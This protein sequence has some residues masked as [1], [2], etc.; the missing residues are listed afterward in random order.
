M[1]YLNRK[2]TAQA[3]KFIGYNQIKLWI[4]F[5]TFIVLMALLIV[6]LVYINASSGDAYNKQVL[7]QLNYSS[8]TIPYRRGDITDRNGTVLATSEKV[9]NLIVDAYVMINSR[10]ESE[11]DCLV[12]SF[13]MLWKR[14]LTGNRF[15]MRVSG[16][17]KSGKPL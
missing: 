8:T 11:G 12:S 10:V 9:Y 17:G 14:T 3:K 15:E 16:R 1:P 7:S 5:A 4:V 6:R 2:K 13:G